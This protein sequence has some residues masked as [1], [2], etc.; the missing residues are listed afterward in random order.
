MQAPDLFK[1][2]SSARK[3]KLRL[4]VVGPTRLVRFVERKLNKIKFKFQARALECL[5]TLFSVLSLVDLSTSTEVQ[6][7]LSLPFG[8]NLSPLCIAAA[9]TRNA[10]LLLSSDV[11]PGRVPPPRASGHSLLMQINCSDAQKFAS[12]SCCQLGPSEWSARESVLSLKLSASNRKWWPSDIPTC[13]WFVGQPELGIIKIS[14]A[15]L[16]LARCLMSCSRAR[17]SA[18]CSGAKANCCCCWAPMT[19]TMGSNRSKSR[20]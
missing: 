1:L 19:T 15:E 10:T 16:S 3:P 14:L 6:R 11:S 12:L 7:R 20:D 5:A 9:N 18:S 17:Q 8:Q 13:D 4:F 2:L